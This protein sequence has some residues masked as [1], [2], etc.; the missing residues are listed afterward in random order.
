MLSRVEDCGLPL[1]PLWVAPLLE[2]V[3][4]KGLRSQGDN[5][6]AIPA[7]HKPHTESSCWGHGVLPMALTMLHVNLAVRIHVN[8]Q[9]KWPIINPI[10]VFVSFFQVGASKS[11]RG[12][13][14]T[15]HI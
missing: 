13:P 6:L 9:I 10:S 7:G 4:L 3:Q 12:L 2:V 1:E 5:L 15:T 11:P 14:D 8:S